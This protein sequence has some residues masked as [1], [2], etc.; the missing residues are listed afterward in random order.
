MYKEPK[1]GDNA[2]TCPHCGVLAQQKWNTGITYNATGKKIIQFCDISRCQACNVSV[3]WHLEEIVYPPLKPHHIPNPD[4]S[5]DIIKTYEEAV[6]IFH[7]SPRSAAALL[8]LCVQMLC[9]QLGE[10]GK[11]IDDDIKSL[12]KKGLPETIQQAL[13]IVRVTG[14]N[15][16]HP[17]TI[18]DT[19]DKDIVI[20]LFDMVNQIAK[21]LIS[22]P[23]STQAA[24][25]N[26]PE[27][28]R[29]KIKKRDGKA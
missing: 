29:N 2:F 21:V 6:K 17:S 13:D 23:K 10:P 19:D 26:L 16:V 1:Y 7:A 9:K 4:M 5:P 24:Y 22:I 14:N 15:A 11:N 3:I 18:M 12:V 8:R 20:T 27:A 25:D 28:I